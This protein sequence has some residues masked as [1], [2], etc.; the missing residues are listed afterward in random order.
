MLVAVVLAR[1]LDDLVVG[2]LTRRLTDQAL[3]VVQFEVHGRGRYRSAS[4][5]LTRAMPP[6]TRYARSGDLHIAYQVVG[7]GPLD[8]V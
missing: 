4:T 7:D 8:L 3:L 1:A 2:E 6:E 5:R